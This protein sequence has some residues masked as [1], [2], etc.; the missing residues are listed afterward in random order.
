MRGRFGLVAALCAL[1]WALAASPALAR[2]PSPRTALPNPGAGGTR[3]AAVT[4][5]PDS[6]VH[7][8]H[9]EA[10]AT[11]SLTGRGAATSPAPWIALALALLALIAWRPRRAV[12]TA[13][14]VLLSVAAF[15]AG[16]HS[17][18]HL[19]QQ[20]DATRC[21]LAAAA[22]HLAGITVSLAAGDVP[23][24]AASPIVLP[25]DR[26]AGRSTALRPDAGRAPPARP[27][28]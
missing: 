9:S 25:G 16:F 17:V 20:K 8:G 21:P 3:T 14:L 26:P 4:L 11:P 18:H 27:L 5:A 7:C 19:D 10:T 24:I 28:A 1:L 23:L 22:A 12:A 6:G 13:L 15:Q 2:D